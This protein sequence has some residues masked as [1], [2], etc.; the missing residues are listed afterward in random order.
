LALARRAE[1]IRRASL[2]SDE[3]S[4][5]NAADALAARFAV[6]RA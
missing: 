5:V 4:T 1:M 3:Q 6:P 2:R